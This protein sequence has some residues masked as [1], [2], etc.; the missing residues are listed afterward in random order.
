METEKFNISDTKKL[1]RA[2]MKLVLGGMMAEC[3]LGVCSATGP[4]ECPDGCNC[5]GEDI[6]GDGTVTF[7]C[8][9]GVLA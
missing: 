9:K 3:E 2:E 5:S 8:I 6:F 7:S 1:T 4:D